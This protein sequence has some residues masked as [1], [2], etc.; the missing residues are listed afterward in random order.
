MKNYVMNKGLFIKYV[1]ASTFLVSCYSPKENKDA[2]PVSLT[3]EIFPLTKY[4]FNNPYNCTY[5]NGYLLLEDFDKDYLFKVVNLA[6][7]DVTSTGK[8]GDGPGELKFPSTI[9]RLSKPEKLGINLRPKFLFF[10]V[11]LNQF[12]SGIFQPNLDSTAKVDFNYQKVIKVNDS[13]LIGTGIF[14]NRYVVSDNMGK[15]LYQ[16]GEY[17]FRDKLKGKN[18]QNIAM[19]YQGDLDIKP[20]GTKIVSSAEC[21]VYLEI[22]TVESGKKI[23]VHK[24][25]AET[26]P[27]FDSDNQPG[28]IAA[29]IKPSN[30]HGFRDICVTDKYIFALFSGETYEEVGSL[31]YAPKNVIVYDW[32]GRLIMKLSLSHRVSSIAVDDN[33]EKL[34]AITYSAEPRLVSFSLPKELSNNF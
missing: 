4:S 29:S 6:T 2:E 10:E 9:Y 1:L 12:L 30:I 11:T 18:W 25:I 28:I 24:A 33:C 3:A 34:Y 26:F 7:G 19:A 27:D 8:V 21:A 14:Q 22:L 13:T 23:S 17:P 20:D 31:V 32:D 16:F 15:P 5:I